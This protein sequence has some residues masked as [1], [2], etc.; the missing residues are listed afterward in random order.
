MSVEN[1]KDNLT[2]NTITR[3]QTK[4]NSKPAEIT[5]P[6]PVPSPDA[7]GGGDTQTAT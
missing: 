6:L 1:K 3:S 4:N 7:K 2:T 5:P